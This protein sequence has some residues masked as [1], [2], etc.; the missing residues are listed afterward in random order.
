M[1]Q[2]G[3]S[4][5]HPISDHHPWAHQDVSAVSILLPPR[6]EC[7]GDAAR[8]PSASR[9]GWHSR[10]VVQVH[11]ELQGRGTSGSIP[12]VGDLH[13][14]TCRGR[15]RGRAG[16]AGVRIPPEHHPVGVK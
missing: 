7:P 3:P 14:D 11:K 12:S 10:D 8:G 4:W 13:W 2:L 16:S 1:V 9:T 15:E 5:D 6:P